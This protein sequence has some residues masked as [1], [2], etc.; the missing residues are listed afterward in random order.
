M[1]IRGDGKRA[2]DGEP[3]KIEFP[4]EYPI[5]IM[6]RQSETFREVVLA[7][8]RKHAGDIAESNIKERPSGKGT[9][10]S[11]TVTI[12]AT[13]QTQLEAIFEDLKATGQ[14]QMVL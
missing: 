4:C 3:P 13:G 12:V 2:S 6:G 14:V 1:L 7:V 10:I 5:K 8:M 11:I 9:F